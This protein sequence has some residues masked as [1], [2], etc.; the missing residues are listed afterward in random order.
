[1][2]TIHVAVIGAGWFG[3]V[4][5]ECYL[6]A[7][8]M[9][10]D[11]HIHLHTVVDIFEPAAVKCKE[12]YGFEHAAT[13]W[14][15]VIDD[16]EID[17]ID[18]CTDNKFHREMAVEA[19]RRGKHVFCEKPLADTSEDAAQMVREAEKAG[20]ANM[21]DFHY[22]KIPA[23]AQLHELIQQGALGRIYHIKGMFLQD[24]GF[25]SPMTWR[26]KKAQSGGGSI[27]TM[28]SHVI[29]AVRF[30]VGEI[31]EVCSAGETF[32]E[33][34]TDPA[35][36]ETDTC[37]V[38]DA[39]TAL[40][41]FKNGAIGMLMTSWLCHGCRH[42]HELEVYGEKGS[43]RFN[44]ERLNELEL[45]LGDP[46]DPLNGKRDVLIGRGNPYGELFNLKTG[47]GVGVKESI[48]IQLR[49]MIESI[50]TGETRGP[51]FYDGM[52]AVQAMEAILRAADTH[53]WVRVPD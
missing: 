34:R 8:S 14:H 4:H 44:S 13:D 1:M 50:V 19:I 31:D 5:A 30:L 42:H 36:G 10:Q 28:G 35:T 46:K 41:R 16:P 45:W 25:D 12:K 18:V 11:V 23:L 9:L 17:L 21:V 32:I 38:D 37:D 49:D 15:Q 39:M 24:F 26:F 29:D 51:T 53:T 47:M 6:R 7:Q 52:R 3:D 48:T 27:V 22:R 43:A 20:V 2:K 33:T 40:V